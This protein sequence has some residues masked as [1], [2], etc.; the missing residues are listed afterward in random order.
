MEWRRTKR[1]FQLNERPKIWIFIVAF[2]TNVRP[3]R[4]VLYDIN[5]LYFLLNEKLNYER[6]SSTA[7]TFPQT[8]LIINKERRQSQAQ[9]YFTH[10][11]L[12][13][14]T[15][16]ML[17]HRHIVFTFMIYSYFFIGVGGRRRIQR[18]VRNKARYT[19]ISHKSHQGAFKKK[20]KTLLNQQ[21][22]FQMSF[23][24]GICAFNR[25]EEKSAETCKNILS[26]PELTEIWE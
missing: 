5:S 24:Y 19:L 21:N 9:L 10:N 12:R 20:T 25:L 22:W 8:P 13:L 23:F 15:R 14:W 16:L 11:R 17:P 18:D 26:R 2:H 3:I 4:R 1:W 7:R 6:S